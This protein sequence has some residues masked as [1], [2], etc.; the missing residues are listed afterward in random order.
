MIKLLKKTIFKKTFT[1]IELIVVIVILGVLAAIVIPNVSS[2]KEESS[3]TA[4]VS[5][6]RNIQTSIDQYRLD[7]F[8]ELPTIG[9]ETNELMPVAIDF[10]ELVPRYLRETPKLKSSYYWV[11]HWG[12]VWYSSADAPKQVEL[13]GTTLTW[14]EVE[15]AES[16]IVFKLVENTATSNVNNKKLEQVGVAE[17]SKKE[18]EAD[19]TYLV[20]SLD[21]YELSSAPAGAGYGGYQGDTNGATDGEGTPS[22]GGESSIPTNPA[23]MDGYMSTE[24]LS[25]PKTV[26]SPKY[27]NAEANVVDGNI[28][29]HHLIN[30]SSYT[31]EWTED[32]TNRAFN[33]T[34][35][36]SSGN[37]MYMEFLDANDNPI[38]F[39]AEATNQEYNAYSVG[40]NHTRRTISFV[41]PQ[42]AKKFKVRGD[43]IMYLYEAGFPADLTLPEPITN[44]QSTAGEVNISSSWTNP[45][46]NFG[47]IA[48]FRDEKF[49][50]YITGGNSFNDLQVFSDTTYKYEFQT[51]SDEGNRGPKV[52]LTK[53][54]LRPVVLFKGIDDYRAFDQNLNSYAMLTRDGYITWDGPDLTN[55]N[56]TLNVGSLS[57]GNG[58]KFYFVDD[59]DNVINTILSTDDRIVTKQFLGSNYERTTFEL[60]VPAGATKLKFEVDPNYSSVPKIY[61]I[62]APSKLALPNPITKVTLVPSNTSMVINWEA[63]ETVDQVA[64][65]RD[66]KY[67]R[68]LTTKSF[69]DV[70]LFADTNYTYELYP[71]SSELHRGQKYTVTGRTNKPKVVFSGLSDPRGFDENIN[72]LTSINTETI[73]TWEG[74][75]ITNQAL[76]FTFSTINTGNGWNIDFL[77]SNNQPLS[78]FDGNTDLKTTYY[79]GTNYDKRTIQLVVPAGATK[80]KLTPRN[81]TALY[82]Y[83]LSVPTNMTLPSKVTSVSPT[84]NDSSTTINWTKDASVTKVVIYRDGKKVGS[85][86]GSLYKSTPL[87]S[88]TEYEYYIYSIST[89]GSM[90]N[91]VILKAR[92]TRPEIVWRGLPNASAFDDN[93]NSVVSLTGTTSNIVTWEGNLTGKTVTMTY[94]NYDSN[95]KVYFLDANGNSLSHQNVTGNRTQD[96][97]L[98]NT[99]SSTTY[100]VDLIAPAGATQIKFVPTGSM[101][102]YNL[103]VK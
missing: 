58:Y 59:S 48:I 69:N 82:F 93:I 78:F 10:K 81:G 77:D 63:D 45:T 90:S 11:D 46:E 6:G 28:S 40:S 50:R 30:Y 71:L 29:T 33:V 89:E 86:T 103:Q 101:N 62:S 88:D 39:I 72:S 43:N 80:L 52:F 47:R 83:D 95:S 51:I 12:R 9:G 66:G 53:K 14:E 44:L 49:F 37:T 64:L 96:Y 2:F 91:P 17:E 74:A 7:N 100:T 35:Q 85:T 26:T 92:T 8:G 70:S 73:I 94:R 57:T 97:L 1:L 61:E 41:V 67:L 38:K 68:K 87:Y 3:H 25:T 84:S 102:L 36:T 75:D 23:E 76:Q 16:Y 24:V 60:L 99:S 20:A 21:K 32:M 19:G 13:N 18:V 31:L 22:E 65:Y 79:I 4:L 54:T 42:G 34:Y 15:N 5:N 98:L 27:V 56:I 55:R